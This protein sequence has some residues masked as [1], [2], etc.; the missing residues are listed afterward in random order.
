M[1]IE[2]LNTPPP[3]V[4]DLSSR[5][6]W[7]FDL[8]NT[9]YPPEAALFAQIEVR[10]TD[11]VMRTLKVDKA[12]A[13]YLRQHYWQLYGST[14]AG[15]MGDHDVNPAPYLEEVHEIS[16][17][18]LQPDPDLRAAIAALPGRRI[19][20]TNGPQDYAG[21]V[22]EARGLD[23]VFDAVYGVAEADFHSKPAPQAFETVHQRDALNP[24]EA[25]MFEDDPRNL[26]VPHDL[27]MGTVLVGPEAHPGDHIH[28]HTDSLTLFLRAI[29]V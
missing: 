27:G 8:D 20:H 12:R 19:V 1:S 3:V 28:H 9:L 6:V 15:L 24:Q 4:A 14:L 11:Y 17:D 5:R 23:G 13:D 26:Q 18:H 16:L 22:L 21:R 2:S 29:S 7:V 10:M 25:V